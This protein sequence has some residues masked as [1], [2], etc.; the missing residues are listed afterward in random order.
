MGSLRRGSERT[1]TST[2]S[3]HRHTTLTMED[4]RNR[5]YFSLMPVHKQ[6][7]V[8]CNTL[9]KPNLK[10]DTPNPIFPAP[11]KPLFE[12][13]VTTTPQIQI[14]NRREKSVRPTFWQQQASYLSWA[15]SFLERTKW[16]SIK[17][18]CMWWSAARRPRQCFQRRRRSAYSVLCSDQPAII[19]NVE[20]VDKQPDRLVPNRKDGQ[21]IYSWTE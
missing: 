4:R 16:T 8:P 11:G 21:Q 2:T 6:G 17:L 18:P 20:P 7:K 5:K 15:T 1:Q 12:N 19:N 3:R 14:G 9:S 10:I 13:I